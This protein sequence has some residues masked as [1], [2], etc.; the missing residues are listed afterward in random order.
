MRTSGQNHSVSAPSSFWSHLTP[1][2]NERC[3]TALGIIAIA[4][5]ARA[6]IIG[7]PAAGDHMLFGDLVVDEKLAAGLKPLN[8]DVILYSEGGV[9]ISRQTVP[10]NGRYRFNN[11]VIGGYELVIEVEA[12]EIARINVDLRSPL[13]KD[14]RRDIML[15]WRTTSG[16]VK[17]GF[18][19]PP[20]PTRGPRRNRNF[21]DW[22]WT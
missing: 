15:E 17:V 16:S 11:L 18:S 10:G 3:V 20:I 14:V 21:S 22:R 4:L 12:T 9:L 13:L 19:R 8:F 5:I 7:Q 2:I 6:S 1:R